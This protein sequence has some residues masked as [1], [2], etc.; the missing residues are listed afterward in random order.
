MHELLE[1]IWNFNWIQFKLESMVSHWRKT[2]D[3]TLMAVRFPLLQILRALHTNLIPLPEVPDFG[4]QGLQAYL[5]SC[6][7]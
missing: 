6:P 7:C 3:V 4:E 2:Y 5:F 1:V